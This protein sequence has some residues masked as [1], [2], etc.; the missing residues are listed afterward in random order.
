VAARRAEL[1]QVGT[2]RTRPLKVGGLIRLS[3]RRVVIALSSLVPLQRLFAA[4]LASCSAPLRTAADRA[5]V[6]VPSP[7]TGGCS[8]P[9]LVC[10]PPA[11]PALPILAGSDGARTAPDR[12]PST[13]IGPTAGAGPT[14]IVGLVRNAVRSSGRATASNRHVTAWRGQ[15]GSALASRRPDG[16]QHTPG[17]QPLGAC[18]TP[19]AG[20]QVARPPTCCAGRLKRL[21]KYT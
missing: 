11:V 21:I 13:R 14:P 1:A 6:Y 17:A 10:P 4:A 9:A 2:I 5:P 3:V 8:R 19:R 7:L 18:G 12:T 16:I 20:N 15:Q